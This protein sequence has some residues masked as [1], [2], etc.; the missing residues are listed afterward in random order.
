[1]NRHSWSLVEIGNF[2][3]TIWQ[4]D[5][6]NSAHDYHP[7]GY[8]TERYGCRMYTCQRA[9]KRRY[10]DNEAADTNTDSNENFHVKSFSRMEWMLMMP[11]FGIGALN[12]MMPST[13]EV[14]SLTA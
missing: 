14:R 11:S 7:T 9:D 8:D 12:A 1:V 13:L 3:L 10:P 6:G 5:Q 2:D 4:A